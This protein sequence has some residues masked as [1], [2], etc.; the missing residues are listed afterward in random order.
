MPEPQYRLFSG[1]FHADHR[2][3]ALDAL[4]AQ[5][6]AGARDILY[7]VASSAARRRAISD[8]LAR[9]EAVFGLRVVSLRSLPGELARRAHL[10]ESEQLDAVIDELLVERELRAA[11]GGRFAG[12]TP[13]RGLA[14]KAASTIDLLERNG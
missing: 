11:A 1:P 9:R 14:S 6:G 13:V 2:S 3:R 7:I 10:K 5:A 8:L 12:A 4:C